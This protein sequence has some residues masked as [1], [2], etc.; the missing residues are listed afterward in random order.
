MMEIE[1][2]HIIDY[3]GLLKDPKIKIAWSKAGNKLIKAGFQMAIDCPKE[4]LSKV[5]D[6][7]RSLYNGWE[8]QSEK[9]DS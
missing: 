3:S 7:L 2:S 8:L 5:Y 4:D 9:A 6:E 1:S